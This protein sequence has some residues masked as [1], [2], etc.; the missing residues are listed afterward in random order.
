[1]GEELTEVITKELLE[2]SI[3]EHKYFIKMV[4]LNKYGHDNIKDVI[5]GVINYCNIEDEEQKELLRSGKFIPA[6]SILS[7]CNNP[8]ATV[9]FSNC[10]LTKIEEDS[11]DGIF[12]AQKDL[13]N[14]FKYRGGSGFDITILRPKNTKVN[15]AAKT[16]SGAVSFMPS[17]SEV[18]KVVGTNGRRAAMICTIDLRHPDSLDFIWCKAKPEDVFEADVFTGNLPDIASMNISLKIPDDFMRAVEEDRDWIFYFPDFETQR[19]LYNERWDGDYSKWEE[20]GGLL[21]EYSRVKARDVL[22]QISEAAWMCGD[23]GVFFIDTAQRNTFGTYIDESLKPMSCNPCAEQTLSYWN[24]CLLGSFVL[25]KYLN[26]EFEWD[27]FN[28]D[29]KTATR[30]MNHFSDINEN[31]HPL[32]KQRDADH[33]GKRIGIEFT[34]LGDVIAFQGMK[35]G[36]EN[37]VK[38]CKNLSEMLLRVSLGESIEIAKENGPCE[39][40]RNF[41]SRKSFTDNAPFDLSTRE[42]EE[43]LIY[44]LANCALLTVG[45]TGTLSIVS[46]NVSSGLEPIFRFFYKRLNR[47]DEKE[48]SF[49]HLPAANYMINNLDDFKGL[50]LNQAKNKMN[51]LEAGEIDWYKRIDVQ[52][53]LQKNIDSSISSTINLPS[54]CSKE[55]IQEIYRTAW[56]K[57]IKGVTVFRDGCKTGVLSSTED[58]KEYKEQEIYEKELLDEEM[59]TRH[60]VMWKNSK[61]Y[62]NVSVDEE[63]NP[64]EVF[65]KLPKESGINGDSKFSLPVFNERN[66]NWDL[67]SRLIS[68]C[69]RYGISLEHIIEQLDKSSYSLVDAASII[70]RVLSKYI[71]T[72][73]EWF[74]V[75]PEC[76][77]KSYV[78]EGG[79]GKCQEC[80]YSECG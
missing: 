59:A 80:S 64:I 32:S 53:A 45:P 49:I 57:G 48:Y 20:N 76:G 60:R 16:S 74:Q 72:S 5:E 14:T 58:K 23:P 51:Y 15:N 41:E 8:E 63:G 9:S 47:I 4:C 79:C 36:D 25:T 18:G 42:K 21:K 22:Y 33:F 39:A 62:V 30:L 68:L 50:T 40:M 29:I 31:K 73:E 61:L 54:N 19:D 71:P 10:Y 17:F 66:S 37:S 12:N 77:E 3:R 70:K 69:L 43:I 44:G 24:N 2:N 38:F 55:T 11:M 65:T 1:M 35:Y 56:S 52:S 27:E 75:C 67:I 26:D 13:A 6:G 78:F 28:E 46:G 7:A 34:G